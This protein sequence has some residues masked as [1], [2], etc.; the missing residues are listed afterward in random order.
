MLVFKIMPFYLFFFFFF[1]VLWQKTTA[2][3]VTEENLKVSYVESLGHLVLDIS[4]RKLLA[5]MG[6]RSCVPFLFWPKKNASFLFI[7]KSDPVYSFLQ[8][9]NIQCQCSWDN[10]ANTVTSTLHAEAG[11][12]T[13]CRGMWE[14]TLYYYVLLCQTHSLHWK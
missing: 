1:F 13:F 3:D 6:Q 10:N 5:P 12:G 14:M 8:V 9:V 4:L 11:E 2:L 7:N